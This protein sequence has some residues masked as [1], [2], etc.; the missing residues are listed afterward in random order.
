[1][2]LG[3]RSI[4]TWTYDGRL[5]GQEIRVKA[6]EVIRA[7]LSNRLPSATTV[8][9][10][11]W[12]CA[13]TLTASPMSP[14]GRSRPGPRTPMSSPPRNPGTYWFH[15]HSGTQLD[16]G[17]YAP[18]IVDDPAETLA[19]DTEWVVVLDDW[20]DG[21]TGTPEQVPGR[22]QPRQV[23]DGLG[24]PGQPGHERHGRYGWHGHGRRPGEPDARH[25]RER[26][27]G[28][29]GHQPAA[30]RR[31]RGRALP[32][33][34]DQRTA[35]RQ[36]RTFSA[37]PEHGYGSGSSTPAG[38]PRSG[39]RWPGIGM[40]VTHTDG[41]PVQ[42]TQTDALTDRDGGTLRRAGHRRVRSVS[43]GGARRGKERLGPRHPAHQQD[44][45]HP[46]GRA[47]G[48]PSWTAISPATVT[49]PGRY[50]PVCP[51]RSPTGT[52][53]LEL[54]GGMM[55]VRLGDQRPQIRPKTAH[56]GAVR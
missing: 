45:G 48:R 5:P 49:A 39:W 43:A 56:G 55:K 19:Y 15:P 26:F 40:T 25:G 21:V 44:G 41:F 6:G 3:G 31:R 11:A 51:P 24:Q 10:H 35:R 46:Q 14:S 36:P 37:R 23:R 52:I 17:L 32:V 20:L 50:R 38:T 42:H 28:S 7:Q 47:G 27:S 34:S 29:W 1:V 13:T 2:D 8:H 4:R 53:R 30:R 33:L 18:L 16:R 54:T 22:T 9:W 12:R